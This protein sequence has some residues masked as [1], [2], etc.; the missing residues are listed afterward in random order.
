[1]EWL[2]YLVH[3][4][5]FYFNVLVRLLLFDNIKRSFKVHINCVGLAIVS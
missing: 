1:M 4:L 2:E 3:R 5:S